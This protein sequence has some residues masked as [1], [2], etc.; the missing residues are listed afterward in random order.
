[1]RLG[2]LLATRAAIADMSAEFM[3]VTDEIMASV[4]EWE[5]VRI[6][7]LRRE[8]RSL[9]TVIVDAEAA[10]NSGTLPR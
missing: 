8:A 2:D 6:E 9:A 10:L 4:D 7:C 3:K 1:M 5:S